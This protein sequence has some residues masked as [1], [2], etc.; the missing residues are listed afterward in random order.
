L[1]PIVNLLEELGKKEKTW[2][3]NVYC[4][5]KPRNITESDVMLAAATEALKLGLNVEADQGRTPLS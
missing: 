4:M 1:E 2:S 5:L 3:I